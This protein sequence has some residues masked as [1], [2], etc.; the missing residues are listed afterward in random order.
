M[1][2]RALTIFCLGFFLLLVVSCNNNEDALVSRN[3]HAFQD[4]KNSQLLKHQTNGSLL[5][6][7]ITKVLPGRELN[8]QK[9]MLIVVDKGSSDGIRRGDFGYFRVYIDV[10]IKRADIINEFRAV[11]VTET[12]TTMEG[13]SL[14]YAPHEHDRV[15]LGLGTAPSEETLSKFFDQEGIQSQLLKMK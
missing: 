7:S 5:T 1:L 4:F 12:T 15:V 13:W 8:G 6:G 3:Q 10:D 11:T 9:T 14:P 2:K